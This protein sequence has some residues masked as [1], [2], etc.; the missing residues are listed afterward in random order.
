[1]THRAPWT[2][3]LLALSLVACGDSPPDAASGTDGDVTW[4][5]DVAHIATDKCMGCHNDD[6]PTF[7][8]TTYNEDLKARAALMAAYVAD[9]TMPPWKP[10]QDCNTFADER[11]LT[12]D[13][14]AMF[15]AWA[16]AGAPSGDASAGPPARE[17]TPGLARVDRFMEMSSTYTPSP[18]ANDP[19]DLRCFVLDPELTQAEQLIGFNVVPGEKAVVHHALLYLADAAEAQAM[20]DGDAGLGYNCPGGPG[21]SSAQ[22]VAG[23]VPGMPANT[24]PAGT[25]IPLGA[26]QV[27]IMQIHYNT[28]QSGPL[29]DQTGVELML[30][31]QP[32]QYEAQIQ[33]L[34]NSSFVI[35]PQ[36]ADF[37][38]TAE[39]G[40]PGPSTIW[41]IAPHM[42][43]KGRRALVEIERANGGNTCV[44]DIPD[45]DFNW[46]T[47]LLL[48]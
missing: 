43:L 18:P 9:G 44:L 17:A 27:L 7:S 8:M 4:F 11:R 10:A 28:A 23:W 5:G 31:E 16:D 2:L 29:P 40:V 15:A 38:A 12:D 6:A 37:V 48:R 34:K 32:M 24:Y 42:H 41:A 47:I 20:D 3:A 19:N 45:W 35:P 25:G 13:E 14:K 33:S 30:A 21:A 1:M 39:M 46:A 26:G 36:T 22:V